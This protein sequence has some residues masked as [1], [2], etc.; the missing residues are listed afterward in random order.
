M[1][2]SFN[3]ICWKNIHYNSSVTDGA[4]MEFMPMICLQCDTKFDKDAITFAAHLQTFELAKLIVCKLYVR[5][6]NYHFSDVALDF[7]L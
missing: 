7:R 5:L 6:L 3:Y 4:L 2:A 1:Y